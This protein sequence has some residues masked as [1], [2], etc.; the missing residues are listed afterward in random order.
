MRWSAS[1]INASGAAVTTP[2]ADAVARYA[3]GRAWTVA[4]PTTWLT[5]ATSGVR[6]TAIPLATDPFHNVTTGET[7]TSAVVARGAP[8]VIASAASVPGV[9]TDPL[10]TGNRAALGL[11]GSVTFTAR[12]AD[13]DAITGLAVAWTAPGVTGTVVAAHDPRGRDLDGHAGPERGRH[14]RVRAD[15]LD[16]ARHRRARSLWARAWRAPS[17]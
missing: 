17:R 10:G 15:R 13:T 2:W 14:H 1:Y 11:P 16:G 7:F 5:T 3:G 8:T 12:A 4:L 6:I 9:Y